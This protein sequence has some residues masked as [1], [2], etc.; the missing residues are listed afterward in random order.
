MV[1]LAID[2]PMIEVP[3]S[4]IGELDKPYWFDHGDVP[5]CQN[6]AESQWGQ[7]PVGAW[8]ARYWH[9][10]DIPSHHGRACFRE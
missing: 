5:T 6:V 7:V 3:L 4:T 10:A 2:Q 8:D 9:K 1:I